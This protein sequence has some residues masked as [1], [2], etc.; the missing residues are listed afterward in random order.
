MSPDSA[1]KDDPLSVEGIRK[2]LTHKEL[3]LRVF[4]T[5][6]STN[7][8][9]KQMASDGA[10]GGLALLAEA[11][12]A[13]R[14]RQGRSFY[15][16]SGTGLYMSLML[17]PEM[18]LSQAPLL[19]SCAAVAV[20]EALESL[21]DV[22]PGIKWVNDIYLAG[23][24]ICGILTESGIDTRTGRLSYV[25]V[26]IG[27]NLRT[28]EGDFPEEIRSVAGSAFGTKDIPELRNRLAALVL[29]RLVDSA[30]HPDAQEIFEKYRSWS[31]AP[32]K[33][34]LI[35]A[36]GQDPIPAQALSLERDYALRVRLP[37]GTEHLLRSGEISIRLC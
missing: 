29:D 9:L 16:P 12:T 19:T 36:P 22:H 21:G 15:S 14:G 35:L 37:D 18:E 26:G 11:Q 3:E 32:G 33:S 20:C 31:L 2:R 5:I 7:T 25:V 1:Y 27:I 34:I 30:V 6:S 8:V 13:G 4:P 10:P 23:R 24:K 17:R 28:P